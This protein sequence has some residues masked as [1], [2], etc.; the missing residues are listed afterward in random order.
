[1]RPGAKRIYSR[2]L[3]T[4]VYDRPAHGAQRIGLLRAGASS[5]TSPNAAGTDGCEG[6]WYPIE[7]SGY[8][9]L[10][11]NATID[12]EDP[13]VRAT[14]EDG[15][16][17][18]RKLPYVYGTVRRPGPIY[19]RLPT[20]AELGTTEPGLEQRME[21]WLSLDDENG[22]GYAPEVWLGGAGQLVPPERA[23]RERTTDSIPDFL[24]HGGVAPSLPGEVRYPDAL[25][26]GQTTLRVGFSFLRTFLHHGRRYGLTTDLHLLPTDRLRPIRGS[27]FHGVEIGKDVV[28]P[29]AFVRQ[30]DAHFW[31]I[32]RASG[33]LKD[34]GAAPYRAA[35]RLT[36]RQQFFRGHLHYE[37]ADGKYLSDQ[38][39]SRLDGAKKMPGWATAG[40]KWIDVNLSKQALILY[41]GTRA[42]YA[43]LVSSGE[44]GLEDPAH[45]T[46][47]KRGIFR[48][49]TKYVTATMASTELGEEFELR[50]VPYVQYF[51]REGYALHGAYW[52]DRFGIPKS[53]GCI[54]LAPEDARRIFYW[55]EPRVPIGWHGAILPLKGTVLF[56]HQ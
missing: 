39:A 43:T 5:P 54:N 46:A 41:E 6:G 30:P 8:V 28:F 33:A 1:M 50:D 53:H 14:R 13:V 21:R 24:A 9:C 45:T 3:R 17:P 4:W 31:S 7:P 47:T 42:V 48:I 29:F 16:E 55:T 20:D 10:D 52:H 27:D 49:H 35:I 40:E 34:A 19:A 12:A 15:P 51:D 18:G 11:A 22:A 38:D 44:A 25:V 2:S 36:G 56:V 32:D 26:V 37:T 23:W